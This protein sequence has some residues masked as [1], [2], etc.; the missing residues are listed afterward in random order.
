[1]ELRFAPEAEVAPKVKLGEYNYQYAKDL[2]DLSCLMEEGGLCLGGINATRVGTLLMIDR[3]WVDEPWRRKGVGSRLLS[4]VEERGRA[5]GARKAELNTF[6]F[7]APGFY[8][9]R[10][11]QRFAAIEDAVEGYGHYFYWKAL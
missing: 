8:E 1:M 2:E 5:G 4:A 3:L 9:K 10:G 6:G 11:Y 7:Q